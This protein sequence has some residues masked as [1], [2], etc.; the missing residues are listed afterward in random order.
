M[1]QQ[2]HHKKEGKK[3]QRLWTF[4]TLFDPTFIY[5]DF[6]VVVIIVVFWLICCGKFL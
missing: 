1:R 3:R 4:L 6:T 5:Y 2:R